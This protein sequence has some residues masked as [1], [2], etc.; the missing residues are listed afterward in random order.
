[1][2][3]IKNLL[4]NIILIVIILTIFIWLG[5]TFYK[6]YEPKPFSLQGQIE[7]QSYSLSSKA[8]GRIDKVYVKK[9][10][11]VKKGDLLYTIISPELKAKINQAKAG[12]KAASALSKQAQNGT[13]K[14]Q[15]SAAYDKWQKAKVASELAK[16]TYERVN[17][18]YKDGV[19]SKQTKDEAYTKYKASKYTQQAAR[20]L[21]NM[22][23]EGARDEVKIAAAQKE[24]AAASKVEEVEAYAQDLII[25][26]LYDGEVSNVL[27][28]S[29]ELAPRGF[30]VVQITDMKDAW[31][32][33]HVKENILK[34]FKKGSTFKANIPALEKEYEFK[35]SFISVL[36]TF[37]TWRA[38]DAKDDYDMRTFE[39]HARP[40]QQ[41]EDLR[42]GMSVLVK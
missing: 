30:P 32:V 36:G 25:K 16:K 31:V 15:I 12:E 35:V 23:K 17:N 38:T 8:G 4:F 21:Y 3:K 41:I 33:L 13:R 19:V 2:N 18:L 27:L 10:D 9:G 20:E 22:A 24:K 28:Q 7:A 26:S 39:I 5:M 29:G 34:R 14:Q 1:M 42:V 37:A 11:M 6:A 40:T